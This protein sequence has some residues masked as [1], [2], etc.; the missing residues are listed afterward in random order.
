MRAILAAACTALIATTTLTK[1]ATIYSTN[2]DAWT[3]SAHSSNATGQ[4]SHCST[5]VSYNNGNMLIFA[6]DKEFLWRMAIGNEAWNLPSGSSY[7]ISYRI[8]H[9]TAISANAQVMDSNFVAVQL[10]DSSAL[11]QSFRRGRKL[12]INAV[13][14]SLSFDLKSSSKAL[15][16]TIACVQALN[17]S[18]NSNPFTTTGTTRQHGRSV[19]R[20][21][22]S[23]KTEATT[24][25]A[26]MLSS[27]GITDFELI[28][29]LPPNSS[30]H[31]VFTA[32]GLYGA[33]L[34]LNDPTVTV[35]AAV[36]TVTSTRA[37]QC[38]GEFAAMKL[39]LGSS[40]ANVRTACVTSGKSSTETTWLLMP[41][42]KGGIYS[43]ML[44]DPGN[45]TSSD[46]PSTGSASKKTVGKLMDAS[47]K[48]LSRP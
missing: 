2:V 44:V 25:A 22:A 28:D 12:V 45:G 15:A 32:P 30:Y 38:K 42:R 18:G 21:D 34:V 8:D 37:K 13:G 17:S 46:Q 41:R 31:A 6:L 48:I 27:A 26:N 11:F 23:L 43:I 5:G 40:G 35:T 19:A 16:S 14:R 9:G 4:P 36:S 39:P 20:V 3:V 7:P 33:V 47:L 1:A 10:A 29:E 24:L